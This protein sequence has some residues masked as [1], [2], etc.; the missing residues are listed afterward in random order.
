M[1]LYREFR[2]KKLSEITGQSSIITT[3]KNQIDTGNISH[4]YLFSGPR[5]IGK[6]S[7]AKILSRAVNCEHYEAHQKGEYHG[8]IPCN[9]CSICKDILSDMCMDVIEMDAASNNGVDDIR[10]I[11]DLVQFP[12]STC[13]YKVLIIDEVHMLSKSAFNALLKT[14]EEPPEYIIFVLATTEVNKIPA[15]ILSRCQRY[16]FKKMNR[17]EVLQRLEYVCKSLGR[18]YDIPALKLIAD[19]CEGAMRDA[20][21]ILDQCLAYSDYL[22]VE[23]VQQSLSLVGDDFLAKLFMALDNSQLSDILNLLKGA[24]AQGFDPKQLVDHFSVLLHNIIKYKIEGKSKDLSQ[25]MHGYLEEKGE[26]NIQKLI[27]FQQRLIFGSYDIKNSANIWI[28]VECM[29]LDLAAFQHK[30]DIRSLEIRIGELESKLTNLELQ[31]VKNL[32]TKEII[33]E[34]PK[35]E[36][37]KT[38]NFQI[39]E[40]KIEKLKSEEIKAEMPKEGLPKVEEPVEE[41]LPK[42]KEAAQVEKP[43]EIPE[44]LE[45]S[46][47]EQENDSG[48]VDLQQIKAILLEAVSKKMQHL[49]MPIKSAT[50][51]YTAPALLIG[52]TSEY[53]FIIPIANTLQ[54]TGVII[55]LLNQKEIREVR[56]EYLKNMPVD[57]TNH[58]VIKER[59]VA[60]EVQ[61]VQ[62]TKIAQETKPAQEI[63]AE[64][65][66]KGIKTVQTAEQQEGQGT[67]IQNTESQRVQEFFDK[68]LGNM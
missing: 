49:Y 67:Q 28:A 58:K 60:Q 6:T 63:E 52:V 48:N 29:F 32:Q 31:P 62:E 39:E 50:L 10:A 11:N 13:K 57:S 35:I 66:T 43:Q 7:I 1:S 46:A 45:N 59:K 38:K 14:L 37:F 23:N 64:Q 55:E 2:P 33:R 27:D 5:G 9:E 56:F 61:A 54:N 19:R 18:G 17:D 65:E 41:A 22:S 26:I 68:I 16:D 36:E 40:L 8:E 21:S 4:A 3:I 12:P 53:D 25:E 51:S 34:N 15:T 30:H 44:I 47:Q 20:L 42:I 24:N